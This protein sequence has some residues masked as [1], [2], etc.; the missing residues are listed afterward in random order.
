[1]TRAAPV[2]KDMI[3]TDS[4]LRPTLAVV[5]GAVVRAAFAMAEAKEATAA[6]R[7]WANLMQQ[8]ATVYEVDV[9][10]AVPTPG[11][12]P[13]RTEVGAWMEVLTVTPAQRARLPWNPTPGKWRGGG[14]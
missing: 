9:R 8:P 10:L 3:R 5:Q 13:A 6:A 4:T 2:R 11:S 14:P 1:M 12:R 7:S